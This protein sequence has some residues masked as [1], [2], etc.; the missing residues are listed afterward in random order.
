M[1]IVLKALKKSIRDK[2]CELN[3]SRRF[4]I[5]K[6]RVFGKVPNQT[7]AMAYCS[8]VGRERLDRGLVCRFVKYYDPTLCIAG[9]VKPSK[10]VVEATCELFKA[11]L[12]RVVGS[13]SCLINSRCEDPIPRMWNLQNLK[14]IND[15]IYS[16][17]LWKSSKDPL[18]GLHW[19]SVKL[20]IRWISGVKSWRDLVQ[21][22]SDPKPL[23]F[24]QTQTGED[25][26]LLFCIG[27]SS[28]FVSVK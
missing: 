23:S 15:G 10:I 1:V 12:D 19:V 20:D 7:P 8:K 4:W 2:I 24:E 22:L 27:R 9:F 14:R 25:K 26:V 13:D 21:L 16:I 11:M 5:E 28:G 17:F 3:Q 18:S 6:K